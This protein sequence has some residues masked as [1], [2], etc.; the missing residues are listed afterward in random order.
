VERDLSPLFASGELEP[1]V[2]RVFPLAEAAEAHTYV[3][4]NRNLGKVMLRVRQ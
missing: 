1:V 4:E 3:E 2:D